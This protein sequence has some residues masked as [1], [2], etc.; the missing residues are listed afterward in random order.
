LESENVLTLSAGIVTVFVTPDSIYI[1][2][3]KYFQLSC[4]FL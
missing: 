3:N 2:S 4:K 1:K